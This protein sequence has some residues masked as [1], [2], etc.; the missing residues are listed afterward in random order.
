[1]FYIN[2]N[3]IVNYILNNDIM[4]KTVIYKD[5]PMESS[6]IDVNFINP[7]IEGALETLK[8]QCSV[9]ANAGKLFLKGKGPEITT[10]I[11]AVIGLTS[12]AF[13]GSV[14]ICFPKEVFLVIMEKM[15]GEKQATITKELE[16]GACELLNIIF[17][18]AKRVLNTKGYA[19]AKA[20]PTIVQGS[21]MAVRH[22]T[23]SPTIVLPFETGFGAFH[24]EI[25]TQE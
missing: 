24:I 23:P 17:G 11:A 20:I 9:N 13:N 1:M 10:D 7:F 16:D 21:G 19:I 8:T 5:V 22:L 18:Q 25:A 12:S 6:K 15:L 2:N 14:A 4:N 3:K